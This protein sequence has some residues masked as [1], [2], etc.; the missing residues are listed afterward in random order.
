MESYGSMHCH[1]WNHMI[2]CVE[3]HGRSV[4]HGPMHGIVWNHTDHMLPCMELH[5]NLMNLDPGGGGGWSHEIDT[6]SIKRFQK[7]SAEKMG[8]CEESSSPEKL[9][10]LRLNCWQILKV[11]RLLLETEP[12]NDFFK[13]FSRVVGYYHHWDVRDIDK[14]NP[15]VSKI[16]HC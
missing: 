1:V 15:K 10:Q 4:G 11:L 12:S 2:P 16:C 6:K 5:E 8:V 3:L 9:Y 13:S 7:F 14:S